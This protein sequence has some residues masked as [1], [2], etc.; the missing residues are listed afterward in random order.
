VQTTRLT[1]RRTGVSAPPPAA[2]EDG[3]GAAH[4]G[5]EGELN[6]LRSPSPVCESRGERQANHPV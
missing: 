5:V 6:G 2:P 1:R 3:V 4:D